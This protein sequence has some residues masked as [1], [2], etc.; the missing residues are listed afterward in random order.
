MTGTRAQL[1]NGIVLTSTFFIARLC[2]GNIQS[3]CVYVDMWRAVRSPGPDA[4]ALTQGSAAMD[5]EVM[6]FADAH[7]EAPLWLALTY[8]V[9]NVTLNGLNVHWFFKMIA[10]VRKRFT[11]KKEE[12][13]KGKGKAGLRRASTAHE[14]ITSGAQIGL[15]TLDEF[16]KRIVPEIVPVVVEDDLKDMQ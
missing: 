12:G 15:D 13:E 6:R 5:P 10:A 8:V 4:A 2:Y 16:R 7:S 1:Y 11:P 9:A 14:A 3:L